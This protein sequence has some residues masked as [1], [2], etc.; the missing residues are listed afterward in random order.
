ME[1]IIQEKDTQYIK[2]TLE[3][4][5]KNIILPFYGNLS[6]EQIFKKSS[7]NDLVTE[8]DKLAE[9]FIKSKLFELKKDINFIGEESY[10]NELIKETKNTYP[11]FT[12]TCDPI[13]GTNNFVNNNEKFCTMISL[14]EN[15]L[16]KFSWLYFPIFEIFCYCFNSNSIFLRY[17]NNRISVYREKRKVNIVPVTGSTL[18]LDNL[19]SN[20]QTRKDSYGLITSKNLKCAGYE[21]IALACGKIDYLH[22]FNLTPW[23]HSPVYNF[24][25]SSGCKVVLNGSKKTFNFDTKGQLLC[26]SSN[27]IYNKLINNF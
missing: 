10:D 7:K 14:C 12:W 17:K 3:S 2:K 19:F 26:T 5:S 20:F 21:V 4:V 23:D 22:H 16:P 13:D 9:I 11:P 18:F 27:F 6:K 1:N 25:K 8:A 15:K 24:A